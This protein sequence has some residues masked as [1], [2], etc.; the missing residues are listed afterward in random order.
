MEP[1]LP[2]EKTNSRVQKQRVIRN[3]AGWVEVKVWVP[4]EHDAEDI[5]NL[6]AK[7]RAQA[8]ALFGLSNEVSTVES[9]E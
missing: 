2:D 1:A 3:A 4:T 5:R 9:S 6:A 7:R 8:E